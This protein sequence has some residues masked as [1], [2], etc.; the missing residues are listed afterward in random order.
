MSFGIVPAPPWIA[1]AHFGALG[2]GASAERRTTSALSL[3]VGGD[4]G[5]AAVS[6]RASGMRKIL[7]ERLMTDDSSLRL[8]AQQDHRL[9]VPLR[10]ALGVLAHLA[11]DGVEGLAD[12]GV[13]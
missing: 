1:R 6:R 8:P 2:A 13:A 11:A 9:V 10:P 4:G 7:A 12:R 5:A 3:A